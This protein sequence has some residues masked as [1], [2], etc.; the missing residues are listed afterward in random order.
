MG[1]ADDIISF[2]NRFHQSKNISFLSFLT[3]IGYFENYTLLSEEDIVEKLA[4]QPTYV[5]DWLTWS[6]DRRAPSGW[7]FLKN[8]QKGYTVGYYPKNKE[9]FEAEYPDA[10][11][12]C[13]AFIKRE[14]EAVRM[15]HRDI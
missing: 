3:D 2:P 6:E 10:L 5:Q 12:A 1:L 15:N 7:Y 9:S 14:A 11:K 4:E 13:A 8:E